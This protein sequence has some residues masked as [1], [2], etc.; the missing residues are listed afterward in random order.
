MRGLH[1]DMFIRD[2]INWVDRSSPIWSSPILEPEKKKDMILEV[3]IPPPIQ[4]SQ[5]LNEYF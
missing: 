4:N 5:S 1:S 3:S 2:T